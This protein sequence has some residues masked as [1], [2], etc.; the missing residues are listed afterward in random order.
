MTIQ[1]AEE[2][3]VYRLTDIEVEEVS[4]V[5]R[6]A[7]RRKFLVVK[8]AGETEMRTKTQKS[9]TEVTPDG[10]G[11][12]TVVKDETQTPTPAVPMT[13]PE[14]ML[15][16]EIKA[17]LLGRLEKAIA[18]A[19]ALRD[20]ISK[21]KEST[22]AD[23]SQDVIAQVGEI[24]HLIANGETVEKSE[25][26]PAT[27]NAAISKGRKQISTE[28]EQA[29]RAAHAALTGIV[30][31]LDAPAAAPAA[32]PAPA[33]PGAEATDTAKGFDAK[34]AV[35]EEKITGVVTKAVEKIT[36]VVAS[37]TEKVTKAEA[38][39][40]AVEKGVQPSN[41]APEPVSKGET[42][43]ED[44]GGAWPL[45]MNASD[46]GDPKKTPDEVRFR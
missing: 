23:I 5:D 33:A 26:A 9:S 28:R 21:A 14:L 24:L 32:E 40:A 11:G 19:S 31:A 41:A 12:A 16:A 46:K 42:D 8:R 1:K 37:T 10:K 25:G 35:L 3:T 27:L 45:D 18:K 13:E 20:A 44:F 15:S 29:I 2:T 30:S 6:A 36:S 17:E 4:V 39:I 34:L 43:D 22:G 7:N 38:R